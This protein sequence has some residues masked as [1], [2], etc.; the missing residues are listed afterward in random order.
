VPALIILPIYGPCGGVVSPVR[1][2]SPSTSDNHRT[3]IILQAEKAAVASDCRSPAIGF[4]HL[5]TTIYIAF[6]AAK[7]VLHFLLCTIACAI[8]NKNC[9]KL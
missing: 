6:E 7:T 4:Y 5:K 2:A 1:A 3:C 9:K 8:C